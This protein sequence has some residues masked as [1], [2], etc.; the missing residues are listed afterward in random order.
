MPK[1]TS[2]KEVFLREGDFSN[3]LSSSLFVSSPRNAEGAFMTENRAIPWKVRQRK[4]LNV[5]GLQETKKKYA[6]CG[7][8]LF[9]RPVL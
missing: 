4:P 2:R 8:D 3:Q 1:E 6:K 5:R 9:Y 7:T